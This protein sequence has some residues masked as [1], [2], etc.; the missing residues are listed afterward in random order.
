MPGPNQS[1]RHYEATHVNPANTT[2]EAC[3]WPEA[4]PHTTHFTHRLTFIARLV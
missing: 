1:T 3:T 4:D 2:R